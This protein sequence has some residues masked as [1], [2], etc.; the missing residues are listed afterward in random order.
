M[1][2][3]LSGGCGPWPAGTNAEPRRPYPPLSRERTPYGPRCPP[4]RSRLVAGPGLPRRAHSHVGAATRHRP[5]DQRAAPDPNRNGGNPELWRA[6]DRKPAATAAGSPGAGDALMRAPMLSHASG[7]WTG[8]R[9][10]LR[11]LGM[12]GV[13]YGLVAPALLAW[14]LVLGGMDVEWRQ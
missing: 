14:V 12:L 10:A 8:C 3:A 9:I 13:G 7:I 1:Q 4:P 5:S 2:P 6:L 11:L